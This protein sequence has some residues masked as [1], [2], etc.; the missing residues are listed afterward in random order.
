SDLLNPMP[1]LKAKKALKKKKP[2][3]SDKIT[4]WTEGQFRQLQAAPPGK[5][6]SKGPI[7]WRLLAYLLKL[8]PDV[9]KIRKVLRKR[10]MDESR[11][12]ASEKQLDRMLLTLSDH[13]FVG[14]TPLPPPID[15]R[16]DYEVETAQANPSLDTL[17][18]F[19]S[20]H[21]LYGSF[22]LN[23]LGIASWEER[24]QVFESVLEMPRPILRYVRV[25]FPDQLPP[26]PLAINRLDNDLIQRGLIAS[27]MI[28]DQNDC[29][30]EEEYDWQNRPP[31]LADKLRLLFDAHFPEVNDLSIVPVWAAGELLATYN[32]NFNLFIRARD[33]AKQEGII[34]RHLLRL[35]LL[36][37]EFSQV[38]PP[39]MEKESWI[40]Q[41]RD[42]SE[43]LTASCRV[44]DPTS[45]QDVI[46]NARSVDFMDEEKSSNTAFHEKSS[47]NVGKTATQMTLDFADG[48]FE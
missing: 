37:G 31:T 4:Y 8:S 16:S 20:I 9:S 34:F 48:I 42:I 15:Q 10:L 18:A 44:V 41:L 35:I 22:L 47:T 40:N 6:Y 11:F 23:E 13:G 3:R 43:R 5:L 19:R 17:L 28:P 45:T 27:P 14:L 1:K 2:I 26:G 46:E 12:K 25:P 29:G 24:I 21:P 33:L 30:Q 32:G 36:C 39:D 7:P 38:C